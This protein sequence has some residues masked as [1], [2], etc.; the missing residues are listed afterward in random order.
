V[1]EK[2]MFTMRP[3]SITSYAR[4]CRGQV[5]ASFVTRMRLAISTFGRSG[6]PVTRTPVASGTIR[7]E[8]ALKFTSSASGP[9][10]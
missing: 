2:V 4:P 6:S 7:N 10:L 8:M 1:P 9:T 3:F 5:H